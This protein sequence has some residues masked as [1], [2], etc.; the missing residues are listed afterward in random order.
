MAKRICKSYSDNLN[1]LENQDHRENQ[2]TGLDLTSPSQGWVQKIGERLARMTVS[3][4][5]PIK[6][7]QVR[8]AI[9]QEYGKADENKALAVDFIALLEAHPALEE[10]MDNFITMQVT[11]MET[12]ER[13]KRKKDKLTG[14]LEIDIATL[15]V[16]VIR[17]IT[18]ELKSIIRQDIGEN[19]GKSWLRGALGPL[20]V[21]IITTK[22]M[23]RKEATGSIWGFR[24]K[25]RDFPRKIA[26]EM[27]R[28][29]GKD[30]RSKHYVRLKE[31]G[32]ALKL[33]NYGIEDILSKIAELST[34]PSLAKLHL[35]GATQTLTEMFTWYNVRDDMYNKE[36]DEKGNRRIKIDKDGNLTI[37]ANYVAARDEK[38][39]LIQWETPSEGLKTRSA[40]FQFTDYIPIEEYFKERNV[41]MTPVMIKK[42]KREADRYGQLHKNVY[43]WMTHESKKT[44]KELYKELKSL[45]PSDWKDEDI[46][47]LF[48][49]KDPRTFSKWSNLSED[50]QELIA[51]IHEHA[52]RYNILKP[53]IFNAR[54][55]EEGPS[56]GKLSFPIMYPQ[57]RFSTLWDDMIAEYSAE[58]KIIERDLKN[59][60]LIDPQTSADK[61]LKFKL[62]QKKKILIST[63]KRA[64]WIRD[65]KD[66]YP[67]DLSTGTYLALGEDS[68]HVKHISNQFNILEGRADKGAYFEYLRH[69]IS[70]L[71]RNKLSISLIQS[72][73]RGKSKPVRNYILNLY[74][75]A[76]YQPDAASG[77][78]WL[79]FD[80]DSISKRFRT[81]G[82]NIS[83]A[84][85]DRKTRQ[86]LS[87]MSGNLLRGQRTAIQNYT[88]IIQKFI[89]VGTR[90]VVEAQDILRKGGKDLERII[91]LSGVVDFR[92]FFSRSL[93]D[94]ANNL[95]ASNKDTMKMTAAMIRYWKKAQGKT[96]AQ[97]RK[98]IE[99]LEQEFGRVIKS[100]PELSRLKKRKKVQKDLHR[101]NILRKYVNYAINK[102]YEAAPYVKNIQMKTLL[103][104][105]EMVAEF[106]KTHL[107]TMGRTEQY[108]R[109]LSF[110]IG[111]RAAMR[112]GFISDKAITELNDAELQE[113]IDV[114]VDY[115]ETLDFGLSRQDLGEMGHSNVGAFFTQFKVWS[116][117]KFA[118][119][120][121]TV[122]LAY[123]E[124]KD[125]DNKYVDF[126]AVG[127][128]FESLIRMNKYSQK[129]L[130]TTSPRLAAFRTWIY[131]QGLWTAIWDF[132]IMGPLALV[133]G[134]KALMRQIPGMRTFGGST[135]DL[136]SLMLL[137]PGLSIALSYGDGED[138][139][140]KILD[141]YSRKTFLG[142]GG[143]WT[144]DFFLWML[145]TIQEEDDEDY[146]YRSRN[147]ARPLLPPLV[148]ESVSV[149]PV[150]KK[151]FE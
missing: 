51:Q 100:I 149:A 94:D 32:G 69:N 128:M 75:V 10:Q 136:I 96:E 133:P 21:Q 3:K 121:E 138:E 140:D 108:L 76:L 113:A 50:R 82:I 56:E 28:F 145:A 49:K 83:P 27:A 85:I 9:K 134:G 74:K 29:S 90:R 18:N 135:S 7:K 98:L 141:Y 73:K 47:A 127:Q 34:D 25:I 16:N 36:D 41:P 53:F 22:S 93:T 126:K 48:F 40:K 118:K 1:V 68:K 35:P 109:A 119:D 102:E 65:R 101:A 13:T 72:L 112:P 77:F 71:E 107:P 5:H 45:V 64:K 57:M 11:L 148:K 70:S 30:H 61:Q 19:L 144:I 62:K 129:H 103:S 23:G 114:G 86:I 115:V 80:S 12:H 8:E 60:A 24:R 117:Q 137:V 54:N 2:F 37:A 58:L 111:Y 17:N 131:T 46:T 142:F 120:L 63:L 88:A 43:D 91:S 143:R 151:A 42:F 125:V 39:H 110:I 79:K 55:E 124:L 15:P 59:P 44:E 33:R 66:D 105:A 146:L 122:R 87:F 123:Q 95:G 99:E 132:G 14:K 84:K 130:R 89:D 78:S 26:N 104:A 20:D 92:E 52:T 38:G 67:L 81:V 6:S 106:E 31:H 139:I 147:L 97:K 116:M 150:L 4:D